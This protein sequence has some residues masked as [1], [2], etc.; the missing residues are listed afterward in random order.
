MGMV[1]IGLFLFTLHCATEK[2]KG[3]DEESPSLDEKKS[4]VEDKSP[5][6]N[7][8]GNLSADDSSSTSSA[9]STSSST[10]GTSDKSGTVLDK[11]LEEDEGVL[12]GTLAIMITDEMGD[13]EALDLSSNLLIV[14]DDLEMEYAAGTLFLPSETNLVK[15]QADNQLNVRKLVNNPF[16]KELILLLND[17]ISVTSGGG[18]NG[19]CIML[20]RKATASSGEC[21]LL[22]SDLKIVE[23]R[24]GDIL[25]DFDGGEQFLLKYDEAGNT[26]FLALTQDDLN[27]DRA[28]ELYR[29]SPTNTLEK[30]IPRSS[31]I[32]IQGF[33]VSHAGTLFAWGK[34]PTNNSNENGQFEKVISIRYPDGTSQTVDLISTTAILFLAADQFG[35][36]IYTPNF[37]MCNE[38]TVFKIHID[39]TTAPASIIPMGTALTN[40]LD[41]PG[42][43]SSV[44]APVEYSSRI[45]WPTYSKY[46]GK[47]RVFLLGWRN[48]EGVPGS[49]DVSTWGIGHLW[50]IELTKDGSNFTSSVGEVSHVDEDIKYYIVDEETAYYYGVLRGTSTNFFRKRVIGS[51][52]FVD[53]HDSSI[54]I[55]KL[56]LDGNGNVL[57]TACDGSST[58][59]CFFYT[60]KKGQNTPIKSKKVGTINDLV[61]SKA[62]P[63]AK[64]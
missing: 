14:N 33:D 59:E 18:L 38:H 64:L 57:Y 61:P 9:P 11:S 15:T 5:S 56:R 50:N 1:G 42:G 30:L 35:G 25:N 22:Q 54:S 24:N 41:Q 29:V 2:D 60:L 32:N 19:D 63:A 27:N 53:I 43:C 37:D 55:K 51:T 8:N 12:A 52:D 45:S 23:Y 49:G 36:L 6:N 34:Y 10:A 28:P 62:V 13:S 7:V 31:T 26:Y 40:R 17:S 46:D 47:G 44:G 48:E 20:R 4:N 21:M 16:T 58:E 3:E 39:T